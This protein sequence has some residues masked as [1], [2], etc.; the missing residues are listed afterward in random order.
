MRTKK[1]DKLFRLT[2]LAL[3][4]AIIII[5]D[6]TPIGYIV[7][8]FFS[9]TLMTLPVAIGAV[10]TG[11]SGGLYLSF[12][13]GLTSFLMCFNIGFMPDRTASLMFSANPFGTVF[14]CFIPRLLAGLITAL[15][16]LIFKKRE[17]TG[18]VAFAISCAAMPVLNTVLFLTSYYLFFKNTLLA[19][20]TVKALITAAFSINGLVE[21]AIT[22]LVG[23]V[24]AKTIY[25][26][27]L[28]LSTN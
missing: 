7:T 26:Y 22:L 2:F 3:F 4:T 24:V 10:C 27:M 13:F 19:T 11:I 17:N 23:T 6:F 12:L 5:M 28:K 1:T 15:I 20:T 18:I 16:F 9:I 21:L 8:P 25:N 14:T